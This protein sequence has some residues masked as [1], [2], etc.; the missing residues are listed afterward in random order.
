MLAVG[1]V[2]TA[3]KTALHYFKLLKTLVLETLAA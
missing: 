2:N 3:V 1:F